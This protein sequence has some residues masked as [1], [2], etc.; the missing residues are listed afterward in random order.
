MYAGDCAVYAG[1]AHTVRNDSAR[2]ATAIG[3]TTAR[4]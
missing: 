3:S 4:M 2:A 1:F